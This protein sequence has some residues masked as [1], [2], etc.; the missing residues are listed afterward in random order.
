MGRNDWR[1][2]LEAA[3]AF[4]VDWRK[5]PLIA[6]DSNGALEAARSGIGFAL[7]REG[8]VA[9]ELAHGRL[10]A[11]FGIRFAAALPIT[12]SIHPKRWIAL[13]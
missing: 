6:P 7:L 3:G 2:W 5:G 10:V 9:D 13:L 12:L 4:E 8:F 11:P 1:M